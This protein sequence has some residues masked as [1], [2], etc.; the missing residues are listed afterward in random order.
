MTQYYVFFLNIA[1]NK[2]IIKKFILNNIF[3]NIIKLS[4]YN[5]V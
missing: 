1:F 2:L 4:T 5:K 3:N